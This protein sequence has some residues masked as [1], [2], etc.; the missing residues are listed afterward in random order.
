MEKNRFSA[1]LL[2][3]TVGLSSVG[4]PV[5][6]VW[7]GMG[8][9]V[10]MESCNRQA[11]V[12]SPMSCYEQGSVANAGSVEFKRIPCKPEISF[13]AAS[14]TSSLPVKT[15]AGNSA[16]QLLF[17]MPAIVNGGVVDKIDRRII[18]DSPPLLRENIPILTSSLLI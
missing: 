15:F 10:M 6:V 18:A 5:M 12:S 11:L 3:L 16:L 4:L 8:A 13:V 17:V 2:C 1:I 14:F 7:C 9:E